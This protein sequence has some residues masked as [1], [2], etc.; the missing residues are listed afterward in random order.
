M[1]QIS[2][3]AIKAENGTGASTVGSP[4]TTT[5]LSTTNLSCVDLETNTMSASAGDV[6]SDAGFVCD[7]PDGTLTAPSLNMSNAQCFNVATDNIQ[8]SGSSDLAKQPYAYFCYAWNGSEVIQQGMVGVKFGGGISNV[9]DPQYGFQKS[10]DPESVKDNGRLTYFPFGAQAQNGIFTFA[11]KFFQMVFDEPLPNTNYTVLIR[12]RKLAG[13]QTGP[14]EYCC[15]HNS[16][17]FFGSTDEGG[18][19]QRGRFTIERPNLQS[20]SNIYFFGMVFA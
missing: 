11:P 4:V 13:T 1:T 3:N 2:V 7:G 10:D 16:D 18:Q 6:D 12:S 19:K 20:N 15:M 17:R 14:L 8:I 9:N 5:S